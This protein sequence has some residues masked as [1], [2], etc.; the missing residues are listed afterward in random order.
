MPESA[1]GEMEKLAQD[2]GKTKGTRIRHSI[3][4]FH[5]SEEINSFDAHEIA[6]ELI[7]Y[8]EG[9]YQILATVHE[10][11][12]ELHIHIVMNTVR[13]WDGRKYEGKKDDY[14]RFIKHMK[15]A[16]RPYGV[17]IKESRG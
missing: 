1:A 8:Y 13:K 3:L 5:S 15:S 4:R 11:T 2:Y 12:P 17:K 7:K 16:L 9:D 14:Y 10:D 6:S